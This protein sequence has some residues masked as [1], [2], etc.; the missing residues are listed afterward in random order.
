MLGEMGRRS[1]PAAVVFLFALLAQPVAVLADCAAM[2][3]QQ[4]PSP[5]AQEMHCPPASR[6]EAQQRAACCDLQSAPAEAPKAPAAVVFSAEAMPLEAL[7]LEVVAIPSLQG[8]TYHDPPT[9]LDTS[10]AQARLCVFL[11]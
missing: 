6:V 9:L 7:G 11:I 5:A 3:E 2:P 10:Q 1:K 8:W 4:C